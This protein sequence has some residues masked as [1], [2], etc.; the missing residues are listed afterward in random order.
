VIGR[1][2]FSP[3]PPVNANR[4]IACDASGDRPVGH[5]DLNRRRARR[6][7]RPSAMPIDFSMA[8]SRA[9]QRLKQYQESAVTRIIGRGEFHSRIMGELKSAAQTDVEVLL[10]GPSGV[11]KELYARWIHENSPRAGRPFV[12][13]NC[14]SIPLGLFENEL[15]GHVGGAFTG[16]RPSSD[17]LVT[18]ADGGTLFLDEIDTLESPAQVKLLRFLQQREYRRLGENRLRKANVRIV[19]ASNA[20][21]LRS[22]RESRFREDLFFRVHVFPVR[23]APL[24][25]R[26]EDIEPLLAEYIRVAAELY[27]AQPVR[28]TAEAMRRLETYSWPG[29]VRELENCVRY[30][31]SLRLGRA[32]ES[33]DL[34]LLDELATPGPPPFAAAPPAVAAAPDGQF[35]MR[36]AKRSLVGEFERHY[37]ID[38]LRA[39]SGNIARA[40][41]ASGKP[42]RAFFELMRKHS[43]R[44]GDYRT[45]S[46]CVI[47]KDS[48]PR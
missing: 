44:A 48:A 47:Q 28:F 24:R 12:P 22:V 41:R 6:Q 14:G 32:V 7:I 30:L 40:A 26:A 16:A 15:Y 17:G 33:R 42:R 39:S 9:L 29:N 46:L 8:Q 23:I 27:G 5:G 11:G 38:A 36:S 2:L 34:R 3:E 35:S 13:V 10:L 18:E 19:A 20:D 1:E 45:A 31:T 43:I 25:E 37:I 21:L 4:L